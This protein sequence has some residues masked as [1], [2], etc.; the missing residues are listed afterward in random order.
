MTH[1]RAAALNGFLVAL[2]FAAAFWA[3]QASPTRGQVA[4]HWGPAG[5]PDAWVGGSAAQLINPI[6]ALVLWF[7]LSTCPQ[8]F[9]SPGKSP[10]SAHARFSNIFLAQFV[11]SF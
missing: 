10:E 1:R 3:V 7:L 4:I 2:M 8:G 11:I 9:A 5:H 6:V